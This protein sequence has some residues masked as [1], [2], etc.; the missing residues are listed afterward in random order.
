MMNEEDDGFIPIATSSPSNSNSLL[1]VIDATSIESAPW[2]IKTKL[3]CHTSSLPPF[4]KFH[5]EILEFC[6]F[7]TPTS[8]EMRDRKIVIDDLRRIITKKWPMSS[9]HVFGSYM[10]HLLT[11]SSDLDICV[12]NIPDKESKGIFSNGKILQLLSDLVEE[13]KLAGIASYLELISSAKFPIIKLDYSLFNISVDICINN[14]SG[15]TTGKMMKSYVRQYPPLRP[16]IMTLKVFLSQ[17]KLHDTY[18]GGIGSFVLCNMIISFIQQ[19][20][21]LS[22]FLRTNNSWNL[23]VLLLDFLK[24]YGTTFNYVTTGAC[25]GNQ[26]DKHSL[27]GFLYNKMEKGA[28]F[29]NINKAMSLSIQNPDIEIDQI[30]DIGKNSFMITKIRRAFEHASQVLLSTL[31][32]DPDSIQSYLCNII[33][34]DDP[35]LLSRVE[36]RKLSRSL[37]TSEYLEDDDF[38]KETMKREKRKHNQILDIDEYRDNKTFESQR[39]LAKVNRIKSKKLVVKSTYSE[40]R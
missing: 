20:Q 9:V 1:K 18:S 3:N 5:N 40:I 34:A 12:L 8:D 32:S 22:I 23:G 16:L 13:I 10:T 35:T 33:R 37:F 28:E 2:L 38:E 11:P 15:I 31:N 30:S 29:Y 24:Y 6:E 19:R 4:V 7:I 27:G 21:K 25:I 39:K 14:N 17:R 36:M 26:S